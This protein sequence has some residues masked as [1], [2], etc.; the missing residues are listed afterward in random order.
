MIRPESTRVPG[1]CS[2]PNFPVRA[3][4]GPA[5]RPFAALV[6][7]GGGRSDTR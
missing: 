5:R 2:M 4:A 6:V 7:A 1:P 3:S